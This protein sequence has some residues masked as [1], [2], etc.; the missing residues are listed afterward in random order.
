M[1]EEPSEI[2]KSKQLTAKTSN[3]SLRCLSQD[4]EKLPTKVESPSKNNLSS[5]M[6]VRKLL[7]G[8][9]GA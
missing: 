5:S 4:Q 6:K 3:A 1:L 7:R 2:K 8:E 9:S